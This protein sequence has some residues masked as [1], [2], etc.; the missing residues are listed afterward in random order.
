MKTARI[1][2]ESDSLWEKVQQQTKH[3]INCGALKSIAT[4]YELIKHGEIDFVVRI[5]DNLAR[6]DKAKKQ[7]KKHQ[8]KSGKDFNP[9]LPYEEDLFVTN[10]SDTHLCLLNKFNVV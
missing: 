2:L 1:I 7:Q 8:K 6:K 5:L 9:F 10:I 4:E 3:A